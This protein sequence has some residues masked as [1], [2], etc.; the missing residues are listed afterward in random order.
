MVGPISE[1]YHRLQALALEDAGQV[2]EAAGELKRLR[3]MVQ[4]YYGS[5]KFAQL[6]QEEVEAIQR[7]LAEALVRARPGA[8]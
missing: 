5:G 1:S 4:A 2:L 8:A 6:W 7:R 3:A